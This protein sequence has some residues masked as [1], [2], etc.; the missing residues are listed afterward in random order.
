V[1][2]ACETGILADGGF[3]C[4]TVCHVERC[5][6]RVMLTRITPVL[7]HLIL[8]DIAETFSVC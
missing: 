4:A 5:L 8:S 2:Q 1:I 7:P 6:R 3:G